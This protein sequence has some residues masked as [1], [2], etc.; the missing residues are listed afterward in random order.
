M[1]R[2]ALV[3]AIILAGAACSGGALG[4]T[5]TP[6]PETTAQVASATAT[7]L[8][9]AAATSTP[10]PTPTA[11]SSG[12]ESCPTESPVS[13]RQLV[14]SDP[15]CFGSDDVVV[16]GW[17]DVPTV[18]GFEPPDVK[19]R[20]LYYPAGNLSAIWSDRPVG[21]DQVCVVDG[22]T[23]RWFFAHVNPRSG[24]VLE[25]P[26]RWLLL[27]GHF[28]D[29]AAE[30]CHYVFPEGYDEGRPD[31]GLAVEACRAN[32]VLVDVQNAP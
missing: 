20:W 29:P 31:D 17:L 23:C 27:T 16:R 8:P 18:V 9:T 32:F 15:T 3:I 5:A 28:Q 7:A 19:P 10:G 1:T 11:V 25:G 14:E 13:P 12:F 22:E 21:P 6:T 4:P 24:V 30:R 2:L 26:P